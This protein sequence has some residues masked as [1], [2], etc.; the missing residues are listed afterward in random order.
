MDVAASQRK[1]LQRAV[2]E[3]TA[4]AGYESVTVRK[5]TKRARVSTG[6][7]YSQFA[8]TD[9][10]LLAAYADL[11]AEIRLRVGATRLGSVGLA[12]QADRTIRGLLGALL[13]DPDVARFALIE[14][15]AGGPAA[16]SAIDAAEDRLEETV[17][18]CLDRR[19]CR[20]SAVAAASVLAATL[21][22][23][24]TRL[25]Q[26]SSG[27]A[28]AAIDVLVGW[29]R[30]FVEGKED[31]TTASK[32]DLARRASDRPS[33]PDES[34]RGIGDE[35]DMI[36]NAVLRLA[37]PEGYFSLTPTRVS[38]VAGVPAARLKRHFPD[39]AEGYLAAICRTCRAFF[40]EVTSLPPGDTVGESTIR[41]GVQRAWRR[42]IADPTAA[43]LTFRRI[44]EPGL[45]GLTCR[46]ELI[47]ELAAAW[48]AA[49]PNQEP[50]RELA[51]ARA[52]AL[53]AALASRTL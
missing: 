26:D 53:W 24:R 30:D 3:L 44:V 32:E 51:D 27:E 18:G 2:V 10:C 38:S 34:L 29:A 13:E 37:A 25:R 12:D 49:S 50:S 28:L 35:T 40:I 8:G 23:A 41:T 31:L 15:Y 47:S 39:L 9:D 48:Q 36:L 33:I 16:I 5:L 20:V 1:R 6:T 43:R 19:E 45:A 17:R 21:H 52:A 46:E 22:C 11:M 4:A 7:F 14:V 42:A